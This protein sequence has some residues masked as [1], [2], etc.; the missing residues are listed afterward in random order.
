[1]GNNL[2]LSLPC[3]LLL[4]ACSHELS[5]DDARLATYTALGQGSARAMCGHNAAAT[6]NIHG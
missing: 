1:M 4:V 3:A 5:E 2:L 6:L